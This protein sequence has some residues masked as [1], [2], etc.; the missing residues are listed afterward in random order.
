M[1]NYFQSDIPINQ[2]EFCVVDTETTGLAAGRNRIIEIGIVIINNLKI[3]TKYHSMINPGR[4]IPANITMI[5]GITNKEVEDAPFFEDIA[6]EIAELI[7]DKVLTAH[8]LSFDKS[9]LRKEFLS[10]ENIL[11]KVHELCTVKLARKVFPELSSKSLGSV[12]RHLRIK[13]SE[14][15]RALSDAEVTAKILIKM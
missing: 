3:S 4:H 9:F 14:A 13:N 7:S 11:P 15:H 2:A 10:T 5:T 12:C 1:S 6:T 8:N